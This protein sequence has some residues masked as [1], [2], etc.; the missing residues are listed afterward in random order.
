MRTSLLDMTR[1]R[2]DQ[3]ERVNALE[4]KLTRY[5]QVLRRLS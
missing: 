1:E 3:I 5:P 2:D 4:Q